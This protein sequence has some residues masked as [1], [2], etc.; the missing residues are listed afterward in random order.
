MQ[1]SGVNPQLDASPGKS[2][3]CRRSVW[4]AALNYALVAIA[5]S[6]LI[7]VVSYATWFYDIHPEFKHFSNR[8][9]EES[10]IPGRQFRPVSVG[11]GG[12]LGETALITDFA[13]DQAIVSLDAR[14]Y[15]ED[16]PFIKF[17]IEGLT[18]FTN[19][20]VFW[21]RTD[22]PE[23]LY[24]LPL[25]RSGDAVTQ[26]AMVYANENYTGL[27]E[28][29]AIGFFDGPAKGFSNNNDVDITIHSVELRPFSALRVAEQIWEDWTNPP[30]W[31][32]YS[33]NIVRGIH[34]NGM[35]FPNLV[36]NL[37]VAL[38]ALLLIVFRFGAPAQRR[39]SLSV[40]RTVL[41]VI[42]LCWV[43]GDLLR[44]QWRIE[45]LIDTHERYAGL[46]L[47]DRIRNNPIRCA[48]FPE[49][50][51]ADLLPYF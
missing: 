47:E 10:I 12:V 9:V 7:L 43:M 29:L 11:G 33:N 4:W 14:F 36:L 50:C 26:I 34:T 19:A 20:Y 48:R 2:G 38:S 49:D 40:S 5:C 8:G 28:E 42:G 39:K 15:A 30:L 13:D 31:Q 41:V 51:R 3:E 17:N 37:L 16:F 22:D 46:P 32:G 35:V 25:N 1:E 18:R 6:S 21:R 23:Q 44:W 27:I 45:Q 24:S